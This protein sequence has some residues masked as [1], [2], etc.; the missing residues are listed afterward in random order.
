MMPRNVSQRRNS[1]ICMVTAASPESR[2][3]ARTGRRTSCRQGGYTTSR[4]T[5]STSLVTISRAP[6]SSATSFT[7]D[8]PRS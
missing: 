1:L 3:S 2:Q 4:R 5:P 6:R 7:A 8:A